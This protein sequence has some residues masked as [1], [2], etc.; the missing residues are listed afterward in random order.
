MTT[1][2]TQVDSFTGKIAKLQS[3]VG[4]LQQSL[5]VL[6]DADSMWSK[7]LK[8]EGRLDPTDLDTSYINLPISGLKAKVDS[9]MSTYG[10]MI[11]DVIEMIGLVSS[12]PNPIN[13]DLPLNVTA[14]KPYQLQGLTFNISANSVGLV[15]ANKNWF[16]VEESADN[17]HGPFIGFAADDLVLIKKAED[18]GNNGFYQVA[19]V[20]PLTMYSGQSIATCGLTFTTTET[21]LGEIQTDNTN[22]TKASITLIQKAS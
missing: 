9:I 19:T 3:A 5:G 1:N 12:T 7:G 18:S 4:L 8:I 22:D 2:L 6:N 10:D 13:F 17:F 14:G 20:T 11:A 15:E 21:P 16:L